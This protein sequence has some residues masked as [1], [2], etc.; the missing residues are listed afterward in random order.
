MNIVH[1]PLRLTRTGIFLLL[2]ILVALLGASA[3]HSLFDGPPHHG[4]L[5]KA[6]KMDSARIDP[7]VRSDAEQNAVPLPQNLD[8]PEVH[9]LPA[10]TIVQ[11]RSVPLLSPPL[12]V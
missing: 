2:G 1:P 11:V 8:L 6:V 4:F 9:F 3:K 5:A 12:R 7:N 10:P